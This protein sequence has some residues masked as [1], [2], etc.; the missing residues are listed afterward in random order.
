M[1]VMDIK[2]QN[3]NSPIVLF[4]IASYENDTNIENKK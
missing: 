4:F 3:K 1:S 2:H